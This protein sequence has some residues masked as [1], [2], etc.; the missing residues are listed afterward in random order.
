MIKLIKRRYIAFQ[1]LSKLEISGRE[2]YNALS[3]E[4]IARMNGTTKKRPYLRVIKFDSETGFGI[5]RCSHTA[6]DQVLRL[7]QESMGNLEKL[8]LRTIGTSGSIKTLKRKFLS[9][10]FK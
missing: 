4:M 2:L 6:L 7:I 5:I 10:E 3:Q 8:K 9:K 1:V